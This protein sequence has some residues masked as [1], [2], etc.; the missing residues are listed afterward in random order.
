[1]KRIQYYSKI[2]KFNYQILET[3]Y[4]PTIGRDFT[5]FYFKIKN[6]LFKVQIWDISGQERWKDTVYYL[7]RGAGA[8]ILFYNSFD[9]NSFF[10]A[11]EFYTNL[12]KSYS[13]S[14]YVLIK[15]KY[16]LPLKAENNNDIVFDEEALEFADKIDIIF[17]HLSNFEKYETGINELFEKI[18]LKFIKISQI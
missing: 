12:N 18:F 13:K 3:N 2:E 5:I 15:S 11:M 7:A 17:A 9:R 6:K 16:D 10:K 8:F 1:M 14:I 4:I